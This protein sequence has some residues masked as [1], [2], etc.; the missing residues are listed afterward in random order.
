MRNGKAVRSLATVRRLYA[1]RILRF[2][3]ARAPGLSTRR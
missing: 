3:T 2:N 1:S